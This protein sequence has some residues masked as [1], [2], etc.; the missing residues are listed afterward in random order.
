MR[1]GWTRNFEKTNVQEET[2]E[3]PRT[4]Q[5]HKEL[6]P[7]TAATKQEGIHQDLQENHWTGDHKVNCQIYYR[8]A[9]N[10]KTVHCGGVSL[11]QKGRRTD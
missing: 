4:Q 5:W 8:V 7:E 1:Q 6:R 11:F 2:L 3:G 10:K 9:K